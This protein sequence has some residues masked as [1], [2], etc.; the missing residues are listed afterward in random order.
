MAKLSVE[1]RNE[2][3]TVKSKLQSSEQI[4]E[5]EINV[6]QN[7]IIRG[8]MKPV[9]RN[10]NRIDYTAPIGIFLK[11]YMQNGVSQYDFF[12]IMAQVV[13]AINK[14]EMNNFSYDNLLLD[15]DYVF[16]NERTKEVQFVYQPIITQSVVASSNIFTLIYQIVNYTQLLL[17]ES[18]MFL[19]EFVGFVRN[20]PYFEPKTVEEYIMEKQPQVYSQVKRQRKGDSKRLKDKLYEEP[21]L[22]YEGDSSV[23]VSGIPAGFPVAE[24]PIAESPVAEPPVA[25]FPASVQEF[26]AKETTV[27][28][29]GGTSVLNMNSNVSYPYLIRL[30]NYER[31]NVNKPSFRIGKERSYVDYFV[32]NN[33]AVSRIHADIITRDGRYFIKDNHS[34]NRTFVNGTV[35][36][37]EQEYEIFDG[38]AIMLANEAFEFHTN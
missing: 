7:K 24:P 33:S 9:V 3:I 27:L 38:D 36:P 10:V 8:F 5:Y 19:N 29:D 12:L 26:Y 16:I 37:F 2:Q 1:F 6:F 22:S 25:E 11:R 31:V 18:E 32:M 13:E 15:I 34:T 35:I 20:L 23:P 30:N 4:N 21:D 14:I 28:D 17:D